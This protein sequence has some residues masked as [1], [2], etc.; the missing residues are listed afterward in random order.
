MAGG[1]GQKLAGTASLWSFSHFV[2]SVA[3]DE[4]AQV[5]GFALGNGRI[6]CVT[7]AKEQAHVSHE[8]KA[9]DGAILAMI[10]WGPGGFVSAGDDGTIK[11]ILP[12]G[13]VSEW[14]RHPGQWVE[15][16]LA[17]PDGRLAY[18]LGRML[19][20]LDPETGAV[21]ELGPHDSTVAGFDVLGGRLAVAHYN[22]ITLWDYT[23]GQP[24][25]PPR[26][27]WKGSNLVVSQAPDGRHIATATQSGDIHVWRLAD[28][29]EMRMSG[30][31]GKIRS[32]AWTKDSQL[33]FASGAPVLAGWR[34]DGPGP[35]G[36]APLELTEGNED[37]LLTQVA[38]HPSRT[39]AAC[40]LDDGSI[41]VVDILTG[42]GAA[43]AVTRNAPVSTLGWS[44][45]GFYLL[46]GS[47][48]GKAVI[49]SLERIDAMLG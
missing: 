47:E 38:A 8:V 31:P 11:R 1:K 41:A 12:D 17:L 36:R 24:A 6:R 25:D 23:T 32:L 34:F 20:L 35:E 45:S 29:N 19:R 33:L 2:T 39:L 18:G 49:V 3:T 16:L 44:E 40:G 9:H 26:L 37:V 4:A 7:F 42:A 21:T 22:A 27:D 48:D 28:K 46:A 15:R 30:Y 43:L 10:A 13:S 5:F 14:A